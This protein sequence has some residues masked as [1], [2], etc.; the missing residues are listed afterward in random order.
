LERSKDEKQYA[1]FL[2]VR[3]EVQI[4]IP[5]LDAVMHIPMY[6]KFF[7][8]LLTKKRSIEEP[9]IFILSNECS[10]IIQKYLPAKLDDPVSMC[11][12]HWSVKNCIW[13]ICKPLLSLY[14]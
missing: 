2:E 12:P 6:A 14:S 5:I 9:E 8:E 1:K 4:T 11:C 13:G 10:A 3:R 7:K